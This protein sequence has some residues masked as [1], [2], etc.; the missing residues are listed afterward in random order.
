MGFLYNIFIERIDPGIKL[1]VEEYSPILKDVLWSTVVQHG[2]YSNI[3]NYALAGLN[4]E[5]LSE[6]SIIELIYKERSKVVDGK[7]VYFPRVNSSWKSGLLDRFNQE[8]Q[9]ALNELKK[10][11]P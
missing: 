2:P 6:E 10:L 1:K 9:L 5:I 11:R 3:V 8:R 4:L 7:L